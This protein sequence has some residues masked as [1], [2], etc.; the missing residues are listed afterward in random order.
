M[1][2]KIFTYS[3]QT[4][5]L[6]IL[7]MDIDIDETMLGDSLTLSIKI[8]S[9][10]SHLTICMSEMLAWRNGATHMNVNGS[11]SYHHSKTENN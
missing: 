6:G 4:W 3:S 10:H 9:V 8:E 11:E 7:L 5:T 1:L 2:V